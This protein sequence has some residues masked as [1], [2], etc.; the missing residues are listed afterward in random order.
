MDCTANVPTNKSASYRFVRTIC[1]TLVSWIPDQT[2]RRKVRVDVNSKCFRSGSNLEKKEAFL[3]R[4][5]T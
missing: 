1:S 2:T 4:L 3:R 5:P